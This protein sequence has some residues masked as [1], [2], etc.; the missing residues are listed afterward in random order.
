MS[1]DAL[2]LDSTFRITE[3]DQK[4]YDRVSRVTGVREDLKFTLDIN[5]EIYPVSVDDTVQLSIASTL[6]LDGTIASKEAE[7]AKGGWRDTRGGEAT[8]ADQYD[9]VCYGKMYRFEEGTGDMIKV[10]A[11]FGGLLLFIEGPHKR[12]SSF[13]HEYIYLLMKK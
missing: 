1:T 10:Y 9:Y 2:L 11:S 5:S 3:V 7:A 8:L 4:K 6:S 12:L 13:K